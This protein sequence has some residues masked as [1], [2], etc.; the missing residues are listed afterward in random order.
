MHREVY[1]LSEHVKTHDDI[2]GIH[3]STDTHGMVTDVGTSVNQNILANRA[4]PPQR[5]WQSHTGCDGQVNN[6]TRTNNG[7]I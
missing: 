7:S 3:V 4:K 2:V 6:T 5:L 1:N